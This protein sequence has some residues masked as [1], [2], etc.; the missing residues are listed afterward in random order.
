MKIRPGLC[1]ED[2]LEIPETDIWYDSLL[3]ENNLPGLLLN[4][5]F[6]KAFDSVD[7]KFMFKVL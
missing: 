1:Q 5:D 6:E 4:I 2:K 7:R 3:K